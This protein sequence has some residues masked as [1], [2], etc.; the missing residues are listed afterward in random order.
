MPL[1]CDGCLPHDLCSKFK[2]ERL[3][4][5]PEWTLEKEICMRRGIPYVPPPPKPEFD[6]DSF[7]AEAKNVTVGGRCEVQPGAKRGVV[8]YAVVVLPM[9]PVTR[10]TRFVGRCSGL[11]AGYWVGVQFDEPVGKNNGTVKGVR[12]FECPEGYG[13]MVRPNNVAV[14]DFPPVDEFD[15]SDDE[16]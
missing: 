9:P 15:F 3:K 14:G 13:G 16:L 10:T 6:D 2:E 8:R 7:A 12:Y 4:A 5:D 11:P 1:V